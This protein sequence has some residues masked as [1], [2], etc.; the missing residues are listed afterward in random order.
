MNNQQLQILVENISTEVFGKPFRH[1]AYFNGRLR[2]TGG[3]YLLQTGN[4]EMN[5]LVYYK[6]GMEELTGVIKHELCHY[7]LHLEGKG[8]RH[9]DQDFKKLLLQTNAPRY[10][11]PLQSKRK[12]N[13]MY[14]YECVECRHLYI[15]KRKMYPK[16]YRCSLCGNEIRLKAI[17]EK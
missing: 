14:R 1:E 11:Q 2:T 7:H 12:S 16:K 6:Y 17:F 15:R 9:R 3:R 5:P 13:K 4:I 10:C 8:Y